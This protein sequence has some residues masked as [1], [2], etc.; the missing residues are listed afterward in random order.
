VADT[1]MALIHKKLGAAAESPCERAPGRGIPKALDRTLVHALNRFATHRYQ[2]APEMRRALEN[3][4]VAPARERTRRRRIAAAALVMGAVVLGGVAARSAERPEVRA[5]AASVLAPVLSRLGLAAKEAAP[6]ELVQDAPVA[7][8]YDAPRLMPPTG[9]ALENAAAGPVAAPSAP[10]EDDGEVEESPSDEGPSP[11]A[12]P[13]EGS[14]DPFNETEETLLARA[15]S[16]AKNGK[17]LFALNTYRKLGATQG[18]DPRVLRGWSEAAVKTKGWGEALRVAIRWAE[19]DPAPEAQLYLAR[20]QRAAGQRYGAV[21]TLTRLI[22]ARPDVHE[23][24]EMLDRI[25]DRKLASR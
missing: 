3:A 18:K 17:H 23:A 1:T 15:H 13:S 10:S 4:L 14:P 19:T 24:Q 6:A 8:L 12:L 25:G 11:G 2:S 7:V 21:A 16:Y 9:A 5:R 22:A 20:I